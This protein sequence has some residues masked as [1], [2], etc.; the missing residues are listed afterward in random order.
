MKYLLLFIFIVSCSKLRA[1]GF[2]VIEL[3]TSQGCSSCPA[4]DKNLSEIIQR[5]EKEAKPVVGLS[6]HVDYWNHLG[7]KDPYSSREF[8]ERQRKYTQVMSLNS[9]YTPQMIVNGRSEFVG[10]NKGEAAVAIE[11]GLKQPSSYQISILN[12][13]I[14]GDEVHIKYSLDKDPS[15][16]FLNLAVVEREVE[17]FV[18]RG[19][20]GGKKLHHDNV[21]R[22]FRTIPLERSGELAM[23]FPSL[24]QAKSSVILYVQDKQWHVAG[25]IVRP[26]S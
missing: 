8:T 10:S 18:A 20:N 15:G 9:V 19:E 25:V 1:Q 13:T 21:V 22:A 24:N 5:A 26:L 17:N 23:K 2:A 7:W 16:E 14:S 3:F 6:F 11:E 4:A 12:L